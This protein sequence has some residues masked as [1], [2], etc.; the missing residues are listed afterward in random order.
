M[1]DGIFSGQVVVGPACAGVMRR[2]AAGTI[3]GRCLLEPLW[4]GGLKTGVSP[5]LVIFMKIDTMD[6]NKYLNTFAGVA[7]L[8][9]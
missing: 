3:P 7:G 1:F 6:I 9:F 2:L 5:A 8:G 4:A